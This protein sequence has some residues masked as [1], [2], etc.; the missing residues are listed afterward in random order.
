ML[1]DTFHQCKCPVSSSL[2][3]HSSKVFEKNADAR[4]TNRALV[5]RAV[6]FHRSLGI[7][8]P[9]HLTNYQQLPSQHQISTQRQSPTMDQ[10]H[11]ISRNFQN[12]Q[13]R[14]ATARSNATTICTSYNSNTSCSFYAYSALWPHTLVHSRIPMHKPNRHSDSSSSH[15]CQKGARTPAQSTGT[16]LLHRCATKCVK[17][18]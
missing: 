12:T 8:C 18:R 15:S 13:T 16:T 1:E 9:C 17:L 7:S 10:D 4:T 11:L 6:R 14:F 2:R 5:L 3:G